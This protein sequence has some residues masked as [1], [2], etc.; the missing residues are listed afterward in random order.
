MEQ[1]SSEARQEGDEPVSQGRV[2]AGDSTSRLEGLLCRGEWPVR[3]ARAL[4]IRPIVRATRHSISINHGSA[5]MPPLKVAYASDFHAGPATDPEVLHAAC[6]QLRAAS[7]DVLLLGGD[8]VT[9]MPTEIDWLAKELGSIPAPLGR[10]AVLGNHDWWC[11]AAYVVRKLE[12]AGIKVLTNRNVRLQPPYDRVWICGLDDHWCGAPDAAAAV[13]NARDVR[14]LL[15]HSPSGLLDLA[16]ERFDLAFCG[17]THGGQLAL[18]GGIPIVVPYGRLS[19]KYS[20]GRFQLADDRTLIVSVG[21]GC[22]LLPL[23]LFAQPEVI[24]CEVT[25][26]ASGAADRH[27]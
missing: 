25:V 12:E 24:L 23:R 1:R 8:F 13:S 10:F 26:P 14:I 22:V 15:M 9:V 17:H 4:G 2:K 27:A 6:A 11:D 7:P 3:L 16:G 5:P 18:P 19:R 21:L 20:R